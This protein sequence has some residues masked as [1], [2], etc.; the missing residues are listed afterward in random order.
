MWKRFRKNGGK[1]DLITHTAGYHINSDQY[2]NIGHFPKTHTFLFSL[3]HV[4]EDN[5]GMCRTLAI[6]S[7]N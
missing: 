2:Y 5:N 7:K 3:N 4:H 1:M 6:K